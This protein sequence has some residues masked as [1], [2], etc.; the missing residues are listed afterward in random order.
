MPDTADRP[1]APARR[2]ARPSRW[3][4]R[5]ALGLLLTPGAAL[6]ALFGLQARLIEG[7]AFRAAGEALR[8]P[9]LTAHCGAPVELGFVLPAGLTDDAVR[10]RV[11]GSRTAG[12]LHVEG[13]PGD[14]GWAPTALQLQLGDAEVDLLAAP[15]DDTTPDVAGLADAEALRAAGDL[16]GAEALCSRLIRAAPRGPGAWALRGRVRLQKGDAAGAA[17]DLDEATHLKDDDADLWADLGRA[18]AATEDWAGCVTAYT[19][20]L[21][22][23]SAMGG[24]WLGRARCLQGQGDLRA[25]RAGAQKACDL[26]EAEGCALAAE[27]D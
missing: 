8:H 11:S 20:A 25:A 17:E 7:P 24:G 16:D 19:A 6:L 12:W 9:A 3:P 4:R 21:Q 10:V 5:I 15:V 18:R 2:A 23:R 22:E 26:G 13:G 27:L 14:G 1:A